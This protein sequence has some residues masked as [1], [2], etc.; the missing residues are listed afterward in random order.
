M[1]WLI[2]VE[3]SDLIPNN[4]E[5]YLKKKNQVSTREGTRTIQFSLQLSSYKIS[6]GSVGW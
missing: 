6:R 4:I 1:E 2:V 5:E 3:L